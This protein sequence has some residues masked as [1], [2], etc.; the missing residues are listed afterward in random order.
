M[1]L[2]A[3]PL[4]FLQSNGIDASSEHRNIQGSFCQQGTLRIAAGETEADAHQEAVQLGLR[5]R[6]GTHLV[7]AVLRGNDE[8]RLRQQV[9]GAVNTDAANGH[10]LQQCAL[11]TGAC[12]V[13]LISQQNLAEKWPGLKTEFRGAR[14]EDIDAGEVGR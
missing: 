3:T 8:K 2:L 11:G 5:Q 9:T 12:A 14:V 4:P 13:D 6:T 7:Q 1:L 10:R